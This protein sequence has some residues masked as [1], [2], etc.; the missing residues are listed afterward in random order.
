MTETERIGDRHAMHNKN[1]FKLGL[2][3]GQLLIRPGNH[4]GAGAVVGKL[5]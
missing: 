5:G 4:K 1:V 2:F 3:G